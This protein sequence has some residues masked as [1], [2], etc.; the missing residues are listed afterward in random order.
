[1]SSSPRG[2]PCEEE[3]P[4]LDGEPNPIIVLHAMREGELVFNSSLIAF[5][6]S[7]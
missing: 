2:A 3:V 5:S 1:M 4:A 6:I 7:S